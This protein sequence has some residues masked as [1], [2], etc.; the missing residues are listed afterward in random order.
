M[1]AGEFSAGFVSEF[2][3]FYKELSEF[4]NAGS[5]TDSLA[6]IRSGLDDAAEVQV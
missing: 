6:A 2:R 5:L 4:F 3:T 1:C